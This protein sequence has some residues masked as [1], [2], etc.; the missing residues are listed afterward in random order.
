[1]GGRDIWRPASIK[2]QLFVSGGRKIEEDGS[3]GSRSSSQIPGRT[4]LCST[5]ST[6]PGVSSDT[7]APSSLLFGLISSVVLFWKEIILSAG[8]PCTCMLDII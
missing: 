4:L 2:L 6:S 8:S 3:S 7:V 1:M 5:L